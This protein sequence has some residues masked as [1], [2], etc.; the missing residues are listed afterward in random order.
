[1][2]PARIPSPEL[3]RFFGRLVRRSFGNLWIRDEPAADYISTVLTHFTRTEALYAIKNARGERLESVVDLLLE[4]QRVWDPE[5]PDFN[6]YRERTIRQQIGDYTLF[7]TG[8][9]REYVEGR[10]ILGYYV[11]EGKRAYRAVWEHARMTYKPEAELYAAL[12]EQ[13][14]QYVGAL[15]YLRKVY[16]RPGLHEGPVATLIRDLETW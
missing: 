16:L 2:D 10:S 9:F 3:K 8:I 14:E 1:M 12:S 11:R 6:P 15:T 4:A 13:F 5:Q 7:M